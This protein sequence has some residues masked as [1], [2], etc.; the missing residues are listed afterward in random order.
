MDVTLVVLWGYF[1]SALG[2]LW[3]YSGITSGILQVHFRGYQR[4]T[5]RVLWVHYMGSIRNF[6]CTLGM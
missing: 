1:W 4:I 3:E 2:S 6:K 5:S